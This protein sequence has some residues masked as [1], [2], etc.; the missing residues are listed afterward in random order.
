MI[1][2]RLTNCGGWCININKNIFFKR[3]LI[4]EK[5]ICTENHIIKCKPCK[6]LCHSPVLL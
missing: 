1:S 4:I 6:Y 5:Y 3:A 2:E